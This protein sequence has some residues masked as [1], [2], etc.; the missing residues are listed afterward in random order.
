MKDRKGEGRQKESTDVRKWRCKEEKEAA[1]GQR[2]GN[3]EGTRRKGK[4]GKKG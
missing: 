3:R 4:G 1:R 2:G